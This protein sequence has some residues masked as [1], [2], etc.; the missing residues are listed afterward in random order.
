MTPLVGVVLAQISAWAVIPGRATVGDTI[1]LAREF[2]VPAGW[3]VRPGKLEPRE[4]VEPLGEPD[5]LRSRAGWVVRYPI[6]VW[7]PGSHTLALPAVWQLAP[8]GRADSTAGGTATV[9]VASV[10]PDTAHAPAP[11]GLLGPLRP[12]RRH[13]AAPLAA[14][15]LA[16]GLLAAGVAVRRRPSRA[17]P[18]PPHVPVEREVPD[19]RWLAAGEPKAVATRATWQLRTALARAAPAAHVALATRECLEVFVRVCPHAPLEEL[20]AVLDQLDQVAYATAD[21]ADV[22]ALA[23]TARRLAREL[24]P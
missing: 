20:R 19:A 22:A 21:R 9:S 10:I 6:A 13:P 23:T 12:G 2:A 5:V 3:R 18:S 4:D 16:G 1:W 15:V 8:D 7:T 11:R 17:L 24:A 14:L